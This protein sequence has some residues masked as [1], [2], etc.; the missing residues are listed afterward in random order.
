MTANATGNF[1]VRASQAGTTNYNAA[2]EVSQ[3]F[4]VTDSRKTDQTIT[5]AAI[6]DQ[7]YGDEVTLGATA[8]SNLG[9]SYSLSSGTGTITNGTLTITGVGSYEVTASQ[10]G[11]NTFNP[12]PDVTRTFTVGKAPLTA[13]ADDQTISEGTALPTL[14]L[15][16]TG[17]K[18]SDDATVLDTEPTITT[19]ATSQSSAG[20]YP[21]TLSGGMDDAYALSLVGGTLRIERVLGGIDERMIEVYP[22]PTTNTLRITGVDYEEVSLTDLQGREVLRSAGAELELSDLPKAIYLLRLHQGGKVIH[23]ERVRVQ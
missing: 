15:T 23:Q 2:P 11:D 6:A 9:V 18:L 3:S 14:T 7:V 8:S 5:F 16:Y 12:A 1:T 20:D 22:N 10:N 4:V 19:T 17:F 13:T 21:I